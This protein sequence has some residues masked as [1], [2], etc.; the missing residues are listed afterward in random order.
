MSS[1]E[2]KVNPNHPGPCI[3]LFPYVIFT[4][5][6]LKLC[7][8]HRSWSGDLAVRDF[9]P[10]LYMEKHGPAEVR[11]RAGYRA[12]GAKARLVGSACGSPVP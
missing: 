6:P 11:D 9:M 10:M 12:G 4:V 1:E 3:I 2:E 7:K 8:W 5:W